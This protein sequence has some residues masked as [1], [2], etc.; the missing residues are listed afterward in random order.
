[1]ISLY[2]ATILVLLQAGQALQAHLQNLLGL[3]VGQAV[4]AIL[5]RMPNSCFQRLGAVVVGID[6]AAIFAGAGQ[7]LAHQLAVPAA[8]HQLGLGHRG[9]GG[10]ADDGDEVVNIGQRHRQAFQHVAAV[11]RLAQL[12]HGAAGDHFAAMLQEDRRSSP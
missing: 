11:A 6:H 5:A 3:R 10:V 9:R 7:H 4:Q 1:M 12:K 2:S 8:G